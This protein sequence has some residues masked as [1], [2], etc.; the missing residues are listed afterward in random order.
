M[1]YGSFE[2]YWALEGPRWHSSDVLW[3]SNPSGCKRFF[4]L[5]TCLDW[6]RDPPTL[7]AMGMG[8]GGGVFPGRD[9]AECGIDWSTCV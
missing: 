7:F 9:V 3:V 6:P 5:C 8:G 2:P 1:M 4:L